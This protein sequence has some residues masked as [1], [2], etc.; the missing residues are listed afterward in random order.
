MEVVKG[1]LRGC[2]DIKELSGYGCCRVTMS[3]RLKNM[4]LLFA[5]P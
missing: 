4:N 1:L 2:L 3:A 5:P